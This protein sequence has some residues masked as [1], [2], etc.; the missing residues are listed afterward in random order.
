MQNPHFT[1]GSQL[2][3]RENM[4]LVMVPGEGVEP[5]LLSELDLKSSV[6]AITPPGHNIGLLIVRL[7]QGYVGRFFALKL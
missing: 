7:R 1:G 6:A 5:S 3:G 4:A 2:L